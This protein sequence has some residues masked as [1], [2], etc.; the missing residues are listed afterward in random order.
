MWHRAGH[1]IPALAPLIAQEILSRVYSR[2]F[3]VAPSRDRED[4]W[5]RSGCILAAA[6][7]ACRP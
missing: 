2:M 5:N 7:T 3:G 4:A 1:P 6:A